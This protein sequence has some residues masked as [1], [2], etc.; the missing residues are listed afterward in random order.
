M[1]KLEDVAEYPIFVAN[2]GIFWDGVNKFFS[3]LDEVFWFK[4]QKEFDK[5][6]DWIATSLANQE[7]EALV[8]LRTMLKTLCMYVCIYIYRFR[9][10]LLGLL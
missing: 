1:S 7:V 4:H 9:F 3:L 8:I 6:K 10:R 5:V 2:K